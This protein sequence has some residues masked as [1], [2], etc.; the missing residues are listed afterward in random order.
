MT[1]AVY[2]RYSGAIKQVLQM[3]TKVGGA[4]KRITAV[5]TRVSGVIKQ[6]YPPATT[7]VT[8]TTPG[9][10]NV[11]VPAG[12]YSI[13]YS[14]YGSGAGGASFDRYGSAS[15]A[16]GGGGSGG[17]VQG[18]SQTVT[19]GTTLEIVVPAG[20]SGGVNSGAPT[21]DTPASGVNGATAQ[22][23]PLPNREW[24]LQATG[25]IK[26]TITQNAPGVGGAGGSPN[27]DAGDN[28]YLHY[29]T[30]SRPAGGTNGTSYGNGGS[31]GWAAASPN[32]AAGADGRV[33][34]TFTAIS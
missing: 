8:Y 30:G 9:T 29:G 24:T 33:D 20:G 4:I 19:P 26:G 6:I 1:K 7:T 13:T 10:Y 31:G 22:I 27:G 15:Y 14:V 28:G 25:G 34:V 16:G 2:T 23:Q 3:N 11:V 18:G 12:C 21:F 17:Y 32:G 5:Y